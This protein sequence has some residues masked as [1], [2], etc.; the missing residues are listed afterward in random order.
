MIRRFAML[1]ILLPC[2]AFLG[3]ASGNSEAPTSDRAPHPV[4]WIKVHPTAALAVADFADCVACHGTNLQGSGEAVSCYSCHAFNTKPPFI[5][6]PADWADPYTYHRAY[7]ATNGFI[8]CMRC[9]GRD[10]QGSPAAPS[11]Y[12]TAFDGLNC[13]ADGPGKV[14]H[15]LDGSYRDGAKHGPDAKADLTVCQQCHGQPG[16]PGSNPRFNIGIPSAGGKGCEGCHDTN[17]AHPTHWAGPNNTFHYSAGNIHKACTLCHGVNLDGI[18]GVGI[19]CLNCH[20]ET[21]TF[22]LD[23]TACHGYPPESTAADV[24]TDT[25]VPHRNVANVLLHTTCA[26]CHGMR[27]SDTDGRF[28]ATP[29]YKLFDKA[30]D[31]IGDHWNGKIDMNSGAGYNP[32][33]FGCDNASCHATGPNDAAHR[34]SGSG[35]PVELKNFFEV[36]AP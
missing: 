20:A 14:P 31:T 15:P 17:Y 13:H 23:C 6:H 9:H 32:T 19:S 21:T 11:C 27:K 1:L 36:P 12:S 5:I 25:G 7:A 3:C 8:S 34:L 30:T 10:L 33:N 4:D 18:G 26:V 24:A 2:F 29:N 28:L 35:L 22:T 16:G